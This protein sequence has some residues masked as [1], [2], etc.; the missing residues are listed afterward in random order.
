MT[1]RIK[2]VVNRGGETI[3]T[4]EIEEMLLTP[5]SIQHV[6]V[7][8]V[9]DKDFGERISAAIVCNSPALEFRYL[10]EHLSEK[11]MASYKL[12]ERLLI[13]KSL[14]ITAVGKIDKKISHLHEMWRW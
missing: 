10:R 8:P 3:A 5:P 9:P 1:G 12:P 4:D 13:M 7:V 14:P 6:S 2:D 11:G